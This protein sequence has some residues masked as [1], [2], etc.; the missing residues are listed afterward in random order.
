MMMMILVAKYNTCIAA[1]ICQNN[2][3]IGTPGLSKTFYFDL[4][5]LRF[6]QVNYG[7]SILKA[8]YISF[9]LFI[10]IVTVFCRI[11]LGGELIFLELNATS[12]HLMLSHSKLHSLLFNV[13]KDL[14]KI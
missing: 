1:P 14:L 13:A 2:D 7:V 4:I 6:T 9:V 8:R 10:I 3:F 5:V 11:F 12:I